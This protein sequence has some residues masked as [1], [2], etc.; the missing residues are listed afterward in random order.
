M[1]ELR[2]H[3]V[4][5]ILAGG[6]SSR[7]GQN[8]AMLEFRGKPFIQHIAETLKYFFEKV[9]VISDD[10]EVYKFMNLPIYNDHYKNSGPLAGIHAA[11]INIRKNLFVTSCDIPMIEKEVIH[12]LIKL[13][14]D[15]DIIT[16]SINGNVQPFPGIY[17]NSCRTELEIALNNKNLSVHNFIKNCKLKIFPFEKYFQK[18]SSLTFE[19]INTSFQYLSLLKSDL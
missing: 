15:G 19:N 13:S 14:D 8:K 12:S 4:G 10:L 3:I 18:N 2:T 1:I 5:V 7:M 17:K 11:M 9:I 16:Y 6:K